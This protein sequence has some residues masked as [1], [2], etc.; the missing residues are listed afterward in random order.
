MA[1]AYDIGMHYAYEEGRGVAY[2]ST[3]ARAMG[4]HEGFASQ[5]PAVILDSIA[6]SAGM[7]KGSS[8]A[9]AGYA[10]FYVVSGKV[11]MN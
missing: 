3:M 9:D 6:D 2:L 10:C 1:G 7:P 5:S 11:H 4:G 8:R